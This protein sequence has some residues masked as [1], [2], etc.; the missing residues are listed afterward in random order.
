MIWWRLLH[1]LGVAMWIGG[2][3]S[4]MVLAAS[5]R[6][7]DTTERSVAASALARIHGY[8]VAP[9]A[10]M[11]VITGFLLT[12]SMVNRGMSEALGR[13]GLIVMQGAG[14]LA[15]VLAVFVG[16][17]TAQRLARLWVADTPSLELADKL[18]QRQAIVSSVAG[19]LALIALVSG[20]A[21]R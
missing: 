19:T 20:V 4:A 18:R 16:L 1:F 10:V 6:R 21:F 7:P 3:L 5:L 15:A 8:V 14:V 13:L 12:M 9:G 2:A 11:T 17:P